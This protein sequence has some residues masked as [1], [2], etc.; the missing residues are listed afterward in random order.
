M[1]ERNKPEHQ[2]TDKHGLLSAPIPETL[3]KMTVPMTVGMIA[4]LMFNLV[5]TFFI[6]LLGTQALAAISYTFPVTFG[7]NCITMGIG[8]GL[9]TNIGRLLGQGHSAQAARFTTHGL[10]LAVMLVV[11]ASSVGFV[12]IRPLF[13][14][15]GATDDLL[16]LIEQYMHV[17]YLTIPLLVIPMAGN[18]AIRA[19]GDTKTP[20]KIMMLAG[21]INGILD[22]LLIFGLGPFPE[23]GIQGAAIA[24]AFSWLGALLG[25]FYLL[26]KRE[27]LLAQPQW[28]R[29]KQDW[30]QTLKI[31]TPA[32]L[33]TAMTPLS[34]AILMMLLSS[35]GTAAVAAYG[36]AQRIES[37][38]LLVLMSLTSALTP[39]MAQNLGANN[40]QR[41]FA[42]L[43]IS[44]RFAVVFQGLIFLA[45]VPLSIPLAALFSQEE[46]VKSLLWHYLLV[47]PFSYGFQGIVMILVS[48]LNA[49]HKPLRAFQWSFMRLFVF[50]LPAAWIG[51]HLY[52]VEGLFIGVAVG[53]IL[54]GLLGYMFALHERKLMLIE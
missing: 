18:S 54:G 10:L 3:R 46:A 24:S 19:T 13:G 6:S 20:A 37:I 15:L 28:K 47:V 1:L 45:M 12:T 11:I 7:V 22:P 40:P 27:Q 39:F 23:L 9:S 21:L 49:M 30:Q 42:G 5:D 43:F 29:L 35:H 52:D 16:P 33:S 41:A 26:I 48:G 44:M 4:I 32:A 25:S 38:L 2:A 53:N 31:G 51:S 36:A 14:F 50:T 17:W 8:M 34:G